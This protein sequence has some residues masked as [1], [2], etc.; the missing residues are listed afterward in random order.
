M[1]P[2]SDPDAFLSRSSRPHGDEVEFASKHDL[3]RTADG[4]T[5]LLIELAELRREI[6]SLRLALAG[7]R[8][9][10]RLLSGDRTMLAGPLPLIVK[11]FGAEEFTAA[12]VAADPSLRAAAHPRQSE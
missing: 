6:R 4:A 11:R 7:E 3:S 1:N 12:E 8:P 5:A 10:R 2:S 9:M